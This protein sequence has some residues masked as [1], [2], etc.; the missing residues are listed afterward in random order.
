MVET[1][2]IKTSLMAKVGHFINYLFLTLFG[3]VCV[4]PFIYVLTVSV[5]SELS[6]GTYGATLFPREVSFSSYI[7]ILNHSSRLLH[8]YKSSLFMTG[9]GTLVGLFV[10]AGFAYPLSK[11]QLPFRTPI[12][13]YVLFSMLFA[14]GLIPLFVMVKNLGLYDTYWAVILT[15]CFSTWNMILMRNFFAAIPD[16]LEES[17]YMDGANDIAIFFKIILPLSKPILA[18]IALFIAVSFWNEWFRSLL[19]IRDT[20]KWPIMMFLKEILE[21]RNAADNMAGIVESTFPPSEGI[22]MA[23]VIVM[24][25]P[26]L[27]VYP[28]VQKHFVKGVMLGSIK[29]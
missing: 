24:T 28:F 10:T 2:T 17:A 26:I 15:G 14:G 20:E 29:G 8:A 7:F 9:M 12:M 25:T 5:S 3:L 16:S 6:L 13:I 22:R 23:A 19:F 21:S 27:L 11:K 4:L 18:T 1:H